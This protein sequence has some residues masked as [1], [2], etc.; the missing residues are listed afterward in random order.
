MGN[1]KGLLSSLEGL[2]K[3]RKKY[4]IPLDVF[5]RAPLP[6]ESLD[7]GSL[8]AMSFPTIAIVEDGVRFSLNPLLVLFLSFANLFPLQCVPNFF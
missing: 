6:A 1:L 5:I 7:E 8:E 4:S 3:F 2:A